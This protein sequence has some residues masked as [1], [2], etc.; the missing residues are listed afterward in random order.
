MS[1]NLFQFMH[2]SYVTQVDY[3]GG[4]GNETSETVSLEASWV[5]RPKQHGCGFCQADSPSQRAENEHK[6]VQSTIALQI[7][8]NSKCLVE[9]H[10][11]A[12]HYRKR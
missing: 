5:Q 7:T 6:V 4:K 3:W 11:R 12:R 2:D 8:V 10:K 9:L 1:E